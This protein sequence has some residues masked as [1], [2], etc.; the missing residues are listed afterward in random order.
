M[1]KRLMPTAQSQARKKKQFDFEACLAGD[2]S[3]SAMVLCHLNTQQKG[4]EVPNPRHTS[5]CDCTCKLSRI[6]YCLVTLSG[7][8]CAFYS[9]PAYAKFAHEFLTLFHRPCAT[10]L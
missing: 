4:T 3:S 7:L 10:Y 9:V 6:D 8:P 5:A 2:R 1:L